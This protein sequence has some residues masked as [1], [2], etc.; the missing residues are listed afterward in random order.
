VHS[1]VGIWHLASLV[2]HSQVVH[3]AL[4]IWYLAFFIWILKFLF[5]CNFPSSHF[6]LAFW[7][8]QIQVGIFKLA[9]W[10]F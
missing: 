9:Y 5:E 8:R 1:K 3:W 10:H 4:G 2:W 7:E 6:K